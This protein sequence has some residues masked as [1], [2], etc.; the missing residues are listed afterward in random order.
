MKTLY[1]KLT[2]GEPVVF[3]D[4]DDYITIEVSSTI[5]QVMKGGKSIGMFTISNFIGYWWED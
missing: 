4:I 1:I 5:V 3:H 2:T